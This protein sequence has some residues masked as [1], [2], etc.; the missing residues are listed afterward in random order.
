MTITTKGPPLEYEDDP[1]ELAAGP[2]KAIGDAT[3][4]GLEQAAASIRR[5]HH[6]ASWLAGGVQVSERG[7]GVFEITVPGPSGPL[8][9]ALRRDVLALR[10]PLEPENVQSALRVADKRLGRR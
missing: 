1:R 10:D 7:R 4:Q 5:L 9:A 2:A 3:R 8:L 6:G